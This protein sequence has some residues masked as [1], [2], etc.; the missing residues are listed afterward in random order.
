MGLPFSQQGLVWGP[1][2]VDV[3]DV[4]PG[5]SAPVATPVP[6]LPDGLKGNPDASFGEIGDCELIAVVVGVDGV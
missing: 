5:L 3:C 1:A 2:L 4:D 6:E